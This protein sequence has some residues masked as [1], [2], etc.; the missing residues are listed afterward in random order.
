MHALQDYLVKRHAEGK[1]VVVFIEESQSMP[2]ATL[3]E[4]RLLSNLETR[5][6]KLLQIVL[7]GQPEL[8]ENLRQPHIRQLRDRIAHSFRLEPLNDDEVR[9]YLTF[10]MRA[11]GYRGPEI[12]SAAVVK[13]IARASSGLTRRVNLIA[14]KA[15]LAAFSENTHTIQPKHVQ[16]AL[17]D[18]EF[19]EAPRNSTMDFRR[20]AWPVAAMVL[21]GVIG[22][23]LYALL[24][25]NAPT[26]RA[27][28]PAAPTTASASPPVTPAPH[29][30]TP[31]PQSPQNPG[32]CAREA[33]GESSDTTVDLANSGALKPPRVSPH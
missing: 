5:N 12:F 16:A 19:N 13:Q 2:L 22:A 27:A 4:I 26:E 17:R 15:L 20:L 6:D 14:D 1:R 10:R 11:A 18:S 8:D 21:G 25:G 33:I 9:E 30:P 24:A 23:V 29:P 3:E 31:Q 7:F 28:A 32:G